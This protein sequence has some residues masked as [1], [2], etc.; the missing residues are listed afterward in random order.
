MTPIQTDIPAKKNNIKASGIPAKKLLFP[1]IAVLSVLHLLIIVVILMVNKTSSQLSTI[2]QNAGRYTQDA[3]SMLAGSSLLSETSSNYILMPITEEGE[4][5]AG[6]LMA[7]AQELH[8][9]HRGPDVLARF[10][11]YDVPPEAVEH[12]TLA[13]D[14]AEF[15]KN[16]QLH[17]I[18]LIRSV[19]PLPPLLELE[20]IPDVPL[21]Q[22]ELAMPEEE[23]I[24]TAHQLILG[25]EYGE[26]KG[27]VSQ[28]VNACVSILQSTSSQRAAEA[29]RQLSILR[30]ILWADTLAIIIILII[31][32]MIL[33][34]EII[35]PLITFAQL[36]RDGEALDETKGIQEVRLVAASYNDLRKRRDSLDAILRSA[37][38]TDALTNLPN[39]YRFEQFILEAAESGYSAAVILFDVNYLKQT[40]D[41]YG[42]LAGDQLLC[43]AAECI[44]S[45]FGK[46]CFR[47]GGDEF[48]AVVVRCTPE[49]VG[50]MTRKF[51]EMQKE[52]QVSISY[53]CAYAEDIGHTAFRELIDEADHRMYAQ[54]Q[55]IHQMT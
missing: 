33:F 15:M 16:S 9:D 39:R 54:K 47:F 51:E 45:C 46:N 1:V 43:R 49:T 3:T 30:A 11:T 53:G 40:N 29:G 32:F 19:H 14:S 41:S 36:I 12:L 55:R 28:N 50:Q 10:K 22:E 7:Y 4:A 5:N 23:R 26:N 34:R 6:P 44:S 24:V 27:S 35:Q 42:H 17:A 20:V 2:M 48:A 25:T 38:E 52:K 21:S 31:T 13:S 8:E 18:A 37:A